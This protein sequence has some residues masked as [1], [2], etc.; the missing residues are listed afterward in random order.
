M[1]IEIETQS[2]KVI[3]R[4]V[5]ALYIFREAIKTSTPLMLKANLQ[6]IL[7]Q[8]GVVMIGEPSTKDCRR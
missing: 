4:D 2:K 8:L 7:D 1:R 3:D 5:R 6:F